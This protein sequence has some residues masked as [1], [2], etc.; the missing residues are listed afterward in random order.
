MT[1]LKDSGDSSEN[2]LVPN[3]LWTSDSLGKDSF[4][5]A[6]EGLAKL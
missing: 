2:V 6:G 4:V 1:F 3:A 5:L